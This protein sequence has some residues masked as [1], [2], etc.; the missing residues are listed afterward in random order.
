MEP[1]NPLNNPSPETPLPDPSGMNIK[2][3]K[4]KNPAIFLGAKQSTWLNKQVTQGFTREPLSLVA[5]KFLY[6][7]AGVLLRPLI[8]TVELFWESQIRIM[9]M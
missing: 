2:P 4:A 7:K 1:D 5:S 3:K 6:L 9:L 8:Q